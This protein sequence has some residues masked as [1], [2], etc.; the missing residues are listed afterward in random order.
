MSVTSGPTVE[1]DWCSCLDPDAA[2]TLV[3]EQS[4]FPIIVGRSPLIKEVEEAARELNAHLEVIGRSVDLSDDWV[5]K[6]ELS[7]RASSVAVSLDAAIERAFGTSAVG[8]QWFVCGDSGE[9]RRY[10]LTS[11]CRACCLTS[12]TK[13]TCMRL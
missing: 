5:A 6:R 2:A 12:A 10:G 13:S 7:E 4:S 8:I 11:P 9:Q 1:M 3:S